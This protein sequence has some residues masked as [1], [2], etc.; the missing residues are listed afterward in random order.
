MIVFLSRIS[1]VVTVSKFKIF[2]VQSANSYRNCTEQLPRTYCIITFTLFLVDYISY[3]TTSP[4]ICNKMRFLFSLI[5]V[6]STK[7][8]L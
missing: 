4:P 1:T 7:I 3:Y 5:L 8:I 6:T 2:S